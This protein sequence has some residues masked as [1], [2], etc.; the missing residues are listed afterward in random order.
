MPAGAEEEQRGE[1]KRRKRGGNRMPE[2]G[3]SHMLLQ[4]KELREKKEMEC[5]VR[6]Q[7]L[8]PHQ[9]ARS[10][11]HRHRHHRR[12]HRPHPQCCT[13][14]HPSRA[15]GQGLSSK[16]RKKGKH[17]DLAASHS[18]DQCHVFPHFPGRSQHVQDKC[19]PAQAGTQGWQF[20]TITCCALCTKGS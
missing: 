14:Q 9:P 3:V 13:P 20:Y 2:C 7:G 16:A 5:C 11:H 17:I 6:L 4:H 15:E 18:S 1:T 8:L 12:S 10:P 19:R